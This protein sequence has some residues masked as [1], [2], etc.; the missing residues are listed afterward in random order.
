MWVALW[1]VW[2]VLLGVI[3]CCSFALFRVGGC[4]SPYFCWLSSLICFSSLEDA[5]YI[6]CPA[7]WGVCF[8]VQPLLFAGEPAP[9][10]V[11]CVL[12]GWCLRALR[13]WLFLGCRHKW[14]F[15]LLPLSVRYALGCNISVL[16]IGN[17]PV[18]GWCLRALAA[19]GVVCVTFLGCVHYFCSFAPVSCF[20]EW[21]P[22]I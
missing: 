3:H 17:Q 21:V 8:R 7:V 22:S 12:G 5:F 15:E 2:V 4:E 6:G 16:G 13:G 14:Q 18:G 1:V 19:I 11:F 10:G 9:G 20:T